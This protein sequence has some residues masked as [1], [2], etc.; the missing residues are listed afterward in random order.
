MTGDPFYRTEELL[1]LG[2][3]S[4]GRKVQV[5]RLARF[6]G[7]HGVIG[8]C[9]RIDDFCILK[10]RVEIGS[11]VHISA[12]CMISGVG[13][14]VRVGDFT[15]TAAYVA[16]YT[17]TDDYASP[18]LTNSLVPS[19]L[20]RAVTGDVFVGQGVLIGAHSVVLPDTVIEDF[21]TLGALCIGNMHLERG[22]VYVAGAGRPRNVG[23]RDL[24]ALEKAAAELRGR[25]ERSEI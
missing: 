11:L 19:D 4:V 23:Q 12:Y 14:R 16:I 15:S 24:P 9:T 22:S 25:M 10:G 1:A 20:K 6:Y 7:F 18:F 5:S 21:A 13:G 8:D 2:C 17:A 3:T